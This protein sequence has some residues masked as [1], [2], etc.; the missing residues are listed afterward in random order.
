MSNAA[1]L[2]NKPVVA[3]KEKQKAV[4]FVNWSIKDEDGENILRSTRGFSL[5]DNEYLTLEEKALIQL[6]KDNDGSASVVA[7]LRIV[8]AQEKPESLDISK[9]KLVPSK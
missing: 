9:I 7:E 3:K 8:I 1:K 2:P 4:A 5:Y 6:A